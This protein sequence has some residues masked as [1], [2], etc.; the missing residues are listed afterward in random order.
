MKGFVMMRNCALFFFFLG[1][2]ILAANGQTA[3]GDEITIFTIGDKPVSA[4][5][6][7][8]LFQKN[9]A[10]D[11]GEYSREEVMEYL[12]L[13]VKFKLKVAE[14]RHRK[15]DTA[16]SFISEFNGYREE[17][18]KPYLPDSNLIDSLTRL[19]YDRLREEVRA[20]HI[21]IQVTPDATPED[22]L[23][24]WQTIAD[25]RQRVVNGE[26]FGMLAAQYSQDPSARMNKGDLGYFTA[27]QMVFPFET[28]AYN[29]GV[30]EVSQP[31]RTS[32]GYHLV[33]VTDRR[34][35]SGEVEV[36]HI[37]LRTGEGYDNE[38]ARN[39]IFDLY[40][41]LRQGMSWEAL[42]RE[43]SEDPGSRDRGGR[44]R[45]FGVGGMRAVPEFEQVAFDLQ[46]PG[47]LSDPFQTRFGWHILRLES[48][49]GLSPFEALETTLRNRVSR[50]ERAQ[51]SKAALKEKT[52]R[53][54]DFREN[55]VEKNL[56]FSLADTALTQG[57][58]N[59]DDNVNPD[60]VLFTMKGR[61]YTV[62]QFTDFVSRK[63]ERSNLAP[64]KYMAQRYDEFVSNVQGEVLEEEI[65][66]K[67]PSFRWLLNEYYEGIL[68][69]EIMEEEVWNR[70]SGDSAGQVAFYEVNPDKYQAGERILG[71][72]YAD[73]ERANIEELHTLLLD[74]DSAA[75]DAFVESWR[76]RREHGAFEREDRVVL[77]KIPWNAG[78]HLS[79][80]NDLHYLVSVERILPPGRKTFQE[81]R[82]SVISDYQNY[83]EG[84]WVRA[85]EQKY[86][87]KMK[88]KGIRFLEKELV[89][90]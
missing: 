68:L 32:F 57:R 1:A 6:F 53:E 46:A 10:A 33:K 49:T 75:V 9:H 17:L 62:G 4:S 56:L 7:I 45:P 73:G 74:A 16:A 22:T 90:K 25:I 13:Y 8:Y 78:V 19:T 61:A 39:T 35:S 24:A 87:V 14:A 83:L 85:L 28:A 23:K 42:C 58:W 88:K 18:R 70:A 89:K 59:P 3:K 60:A 12:D 84:A 43:F 69:F 80:N 67:N 79:E 65:K 66:R 37:L 20:S 76:I 11:S 51:L 52:R 40:N 2:G 21:L 48:K 5:E 71:T 27:L 64:E 31:V 77:G 81:A 36:S 26:D 50:D 86:P 63:T 15:M 34:P 29:T 55:P 38:K 30:G 47:D 82:A 44:L 54:L 72:I 41:R